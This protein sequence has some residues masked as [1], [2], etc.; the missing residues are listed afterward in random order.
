MIIICL[1]INDFRKKNGE[2]GQN[3]IITQLS[4]VFFERMN[5]NDSIIKSRAQI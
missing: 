3:K 1:M 5:L 2:N 4:R